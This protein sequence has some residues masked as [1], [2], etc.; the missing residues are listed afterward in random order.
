MKNIWLL[1]FFTFL[2]CC[3]SCKHDIQQNTEGF[4]VYQVDLDKKINP[5]EEIFSKAEVIPL[6]TADSGLIIYMNKILPIGDEYY[7]H[8]Q[9]V[10]KLYV[11][12]QDGKYKR[13]ISRYGQGP[14]DYISMFDCVIDAPNNDIFMLSPYGWVKRFDM[15]GNLKRNMELPA[16]P[17]YY[18]MELVNDSCFATW[19]CLESDEDCILV[20]H[21]ETLDTINCYWRDDRMFNHQQLAPF[22]RLEDKTFYAN[23]LR[24]KV[25]EVSATGLHPAYLWNFGKYNMEKR[26]EYYLSLENPNDRNNAILDEIGT[27]NRPF[28]LRKQTQNH[29]YSYASLVREQEMR[30]FMTHVFY[31]KEN[32]RGLVFDYLG[33]QCE[34]NFPLYMDDEIFISDIYYDKRETYKNILPES[35]YKKLEAMKEDDNP[36]LLKLYFNK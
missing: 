6:E 27:P 26:L 16:R 15:K 25:F 12:G 17:H 10:H 28:S 18:S 5:F 30:P 36:C 13:R 34:L 7:I 23:N 32:D 8:E 29:R 20:L 24:Q 9:E 33:E 21:K 14:N 11:F 22:H 35:E 1:P 31:D 4:R 2:L 19:S 3:I